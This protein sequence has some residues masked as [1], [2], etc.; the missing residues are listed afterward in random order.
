[1]NSNEKN[2]VKNFFSLKRTIAEAQENLINNFG[3]NTIYDENENT[4]YN[5]NDSKVNEAKTKY[6]PLTAAKNYLTECGF[7]DINMVNVVY[8][9]YVTTN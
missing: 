9:E 3:L 5:W 8:S 1:M 4:L 7:Y 6:Q 2:F